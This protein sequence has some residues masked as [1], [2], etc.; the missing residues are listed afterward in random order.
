MFPRFMKKPSNPLKI[1]L[2]K[3]KRTPPGASPGSINLA[4]D[5]KSPRLSIISFDKESLFELPVQNLN[6]IH[7][8]MNQYPD[9]LHWIEI[10][11]F[12]DKNLLESICA[13]FDIH[14]LEMEDVISTYQRPKMEEHKD[15][16]F[17]VTRVLTRSQDGLMRNDQLSLFVGKKFVISMQEQ[18]DDYFEPVRSRIRTG[19]GNLRNSGTDYLMYTLLDSIVDTYFP[20]LEA[21]GD[22]LD[23][24]EDELFLKP[25]R[26][27]LQ[28]IQ[29]IKREL[30]VFRRTVFAERDKIN[31]VLRTHTNFVNDQTKL[32]L[33][34]TY[35]HIIQV[36]DLVESY[37]EI[38]ASLMDIY[39]SSVSNRMNQIMKVLAVIS[40]IF[41]PLT[42]IVGVYGM[43]FPDQNPVTGE[44]LPLNMPE[45][46]SPYGYIGVMLFM[47]L[48]SIIQLYIFWRK[49]WLEKA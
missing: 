30:I 37:K 13:E 44:K 45:L 35:D 11:G 15:H 17:F 23:E 9:L 24:L 10:R 26:I 4:E 46:Y 38:T 31:D 14:R 22:K 34:D 29:T 28:K 43:N 19:K 20:I 18:Y 3:H 41:I 12:G 48:L 7:Q 32:F 40:T 25:N 6:D 42:F 33:R 39:L 1:S 5:A 36:M 8:R 47:F 2:R 21:I 16:L 27:S 49:G